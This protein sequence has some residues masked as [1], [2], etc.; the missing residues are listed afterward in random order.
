VSNGQ[1]LA[2][3]F[4]AALDGVA[5]FLPEGSARRTAD[6]GQPEYG[7]AAPQ[8]P[9]SPSIG[10]GSLVVFRHRKFGAEMKGRIVSIRSDGRFVVRPL[11][12][13][14]GNRWEKV[15]YTRTVT[16]RDVRLLDV[17]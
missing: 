11:A 2:E 16:V 4:A 17:S 13:R 12:M 8:E 1:I 5:R 6:S 14:W 9:G 7:G 10:V 15:T 3:F